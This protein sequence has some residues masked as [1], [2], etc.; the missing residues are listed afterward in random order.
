M[1]LG[2]W[3]LGR[4]VVSGV[5]VVVPVPLVVDRTATVVP[6]FPSGPTGGGGVVHRSLTST[7]G[8]RHRTTAA[9][10]THARRPTAR[11]RGRAADPSTPSRESANAPM[12]GNR[13]AGFFARAFRT[14]ASSRESISGRTDDGGSGLVPRTWV[15]I[16]TLVPANGGCPVAI[17]YNTAPR[18][19]TSLA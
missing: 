18:L 7:G 13:S 10:E 6:P 9:A 14:M 5:A 17:S 2:F 3:I 19:Y 15:K 8:R 12:S 11:R 1:G 4:R 16:S